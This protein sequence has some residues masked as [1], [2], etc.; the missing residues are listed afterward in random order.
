[1]CAGHER[2]G[3]LVAHLD[4]PDAILAVPDRLHDPVDAVARH[5]EDG[6]HTPRDE[7]FD[8]QVRAVERRACGNGLEMGGHY[9]SGA[10]VCW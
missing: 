2:R 8:Q 7:A 5:A 1:M 6:V 10:W 9:L 3:F 4:E